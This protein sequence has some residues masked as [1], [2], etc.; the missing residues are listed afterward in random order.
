MTSE[1]VAGSAGT[2]G[3]GVRENRGFI[4]GNL[5][6]GHGIT[7]WY[8]D[9]FNVVIPTIA[10]DLGLSGVQIGS[11]ALVRN[12]TSGLLVIPAGFAIDMA[13]RRWGLIM[14]TCMVWIAIAYAIMGFAPNYWVLLPAMVLI[15]M[16]G[17]IWHL[18]AIAALSLRFPE[19]RGF[20]LSFHGVGGNIG[21]S[22]G[23]LAASGLLAL[24]FWRHVF[25]VYAIPALIV[26]G[27]V[28][29]SLKNLGGAEK[30]KG[31]SLRARVRAAGKMLRNPMVL[32]LLASSVLRGM[33][34]TAI[35]AFLPVFLV[36]ERGF[37]GDSLKLGLYVT[38]M[39]GMSTL[40]SPVL[41]ILSD[42]IGRKA[43]LV[44]GTLVVGV[45]SMVM[46]QVGAGWELI[47]VLAGIGLFTYSMGQIIQVA[48][49]DVVG[50]GR[51]ATAIGI[52][53]GAQLSLVAISPLIAGAIKDS[54][55]TSYIFYYAGGVTLLSTV[56]L[57]SLPLKKGE[58][59]A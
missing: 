12:L 35:T 37:A 30:Q 58:S 4:L 5:A 59:G 49:I 11:L 23:P 41:G 43:I 24:L 17:S 39:T 14:T 47:P 1:A 21:S 48:I 7:H 52:L 10:A 29:W 22:L 38:V 34:N 25:Y 46:V 51:A 57:F 36:D 18:P 8:S 9:S 15:A 13:R 56:M 19:K 20:A 44:M 6:A 32:G 50:S 26:A 16:P 28:W 53:Q 55:G 3:Q 45:L 54:L 40:A 27:L 42:R 33:G 2:R 31:E